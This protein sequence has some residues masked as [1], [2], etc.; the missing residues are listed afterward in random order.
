MSKKNEGKFTGFA[1]WLHKFLNFKILF[2]E[3][4]LKALYVILACILTLVSFVILFSGLP[5]G[6]AFLAFLVVLVIGNVVVRILYEF[7]LLKLI[8]A[9]N[10]SEIN[11]KL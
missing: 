4:L 1:G 10:T 11:A 5:F 3:S 2:A 8:V 6:A 9:Q 7:S